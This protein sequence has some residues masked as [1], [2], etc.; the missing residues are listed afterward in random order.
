MLLSWCRWHMQVFSNFYENVD[1]S[2]FYEAFVTVVEER[3][4][5]AT[6]PKMMPRQ[7]IGFG[8]SWR[9]RCKRSGRERV[10]QGWLGAPGFRVPTV[11]WH[12]NRVTCKDLSRTRCKHELLIQQSIRS[13]ASSRHY[14]FEACLF[15]ADRV[16]SG[17]SC[18]HCLVESTAT[19]V[20]HSRVFGNG[21]RTRFIDVCVFRRGTGRI[22]DV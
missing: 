12:G 1:M 22:T 13:R 14:T 18:T 7:H 5:T 15:W 11:R 20:V 16:R 19:V 4:A 2:M 10:M 8:S 3:G 17:S 21:R 9:Y 6:N